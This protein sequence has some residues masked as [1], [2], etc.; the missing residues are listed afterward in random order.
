[1]NTILN[2]SNVI[3]PFTLICSEI[4]MII[5]NDSTYANDRVNPFKFQVYT[6]TLL[7]SKCNDT[8]LWNLMIRCWVEL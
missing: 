7:M 2:E 5:K 6:L 3:D 8:I 1:M 4:Q